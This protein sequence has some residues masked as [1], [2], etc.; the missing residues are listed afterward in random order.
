MLTRLIVVII[1]QYLQVSNHVAH[2]KLMQRM[3]VRYE[4]SQ[5]RS[6]IHIFSGPFLPLA[7]MYSESLLKKKPGC[8]YQ[9]SLI[10][11]LLYS[12][13][14]LFEAGDAR[15]GNKLRRFRVRAV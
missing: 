2:L 3:S 13:T 14:V 8:I 7:L 11:L 15:E 4:A 6:C 1:L 5:Q 9:W 10:I 12:T